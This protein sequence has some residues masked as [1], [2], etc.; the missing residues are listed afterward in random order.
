MR[1]EDTTNESLAFVNGEWLPLSECTN[2]YTK[3]WIDAVIAKKEKS[4]GITK[5]QQTQTQKLRIIPNPIKQN[6]QLTLILPSVDDKAQHIVQLYSIWGQKIYSTTCQFINS[7]TQLTLPT[8]PAGI[9]LI[10]IDDCLGFE[11]IIIH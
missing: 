4:S 1:K 6:E 9:Y 2:G 3:L 8:L 11:K 5:N 10:R 7:Q